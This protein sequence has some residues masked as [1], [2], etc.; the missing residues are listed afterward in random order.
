MKTLSASSAFPRIIHPIRVITIV[1][2]ITFS[3]SNLGLGENVS[4][5]FAQSPCGD[6]YI[7]LPDDTIEG[8]AELCGTTVDA[9]LILNPE[10]TDPDDLFPGQII[11]IPEAESIQ[12][13]IIA[14]GPVCGLPGTS[15]LLAGSGFPRN[16]NVQL[17][18]G[19]KGTDPSIV[20]ETVSDEFGMIDTSVNLP[21]SAEPG[22]T[23]VVTGETQISSAK[24]IGVSNSFSVIP[25][26]QDPNSGTTYIAQE[27]DTLRSIAVKFNRDLGALLEANPQLTAT[28]QLT[29]GQVVVIPPQQPGTPVTTVRPICGPIETR[30]QVTGNGFP[31]GTTIDLSMGEYLVSYEQVGTTSSSPNRTFQTQL[32]IPINAEVGEQWVVIAGTSNFP[33]VRSTSNIFI[34]TPPIDPKEPSLYIV[35]PGDTLNAIAAEYTRTVASILI[36]NPQISN[37]NQLDVGEKIIIPGQRETIIIT[38]VS[39][40][41]LTTIQVGGLGYQPF[42]SVTLGFTR[43]AVVFSIEGVVNTDVNGFF[44]TEYTIPSSAQVGELW[45]VVSIRSDDT[46]SEIT[47]RSNEFTVTSPQPLL[48]PI[49]TI[50]PLGGPAGTGIS[51]VGSNFPS[52]NQIHYTFGIEQGEPFKSSNIWT[53]ING[54]FA[55][56]ILVPIDA[57]SG[58]SWVVTAEAIDNPQISATSPAFVVTGP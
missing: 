46:G 52:M 30:I 36:V 6:T 27:G 35:K 25:D 50:W 18:I 40:E 12:E 57:E 29:P 21:S 14:I 32:N 48:Q 49:L 16:V 23:W 26:A 3:F 5:T 1:I 9:I 51:V 4:I 43:D 10:I 8:I 28:S 11:R 53:E 34:I 37:P 33:I 45:A 41:P 56:D 7:V 15:L 47:A 38:P 39:G 54:T 24:F 20:G 17:S 44:S 55:I 42:S 31:P 2:L 19:E 22:S 58:E 13:T